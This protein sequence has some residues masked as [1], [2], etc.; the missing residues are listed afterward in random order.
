MKSAGITD[1]GRQRANNEDALFVS[2]ERFHKLPNLFILADGMGGHNAG[3]IAS[4]ES[5]SLFKEYC[6]KTPLKRKEFLD[7]LI[8]GCVYANNGVFEMAENNIDYRGMGTTFS[9]CVMHKGKL[10]IAHVGDSRVYAV[11]SDKIKLLT[12][13]HTYVFEM[14]KLGQITEQAAKTHPRRNML[15]R[16]LG[17]ERDIKIDGQVFELTGCKKILL[18][19]DGLTDML[20]DSEIFQEAI[21]EACSDNSIIAQNLI[22]KAN[23]NGGADNI[24]V[25]IFDAEGGETR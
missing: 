9:A 8:S 4:A 11:Y 10:Y 23:A 2:G 22:D 12:D 16:V 13:D 7:Y 6:A 20:T 18:C 1:T 25:I 17:V 5:I 19:S 3:E 21:N 24:S 14:Q 15:I